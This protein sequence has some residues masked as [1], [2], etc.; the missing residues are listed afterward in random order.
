RLLGL[1][2]DQWCEKGILGNFWETGAAARQSGVHP[3]WYALDWMQ[4]SVASPQHDSE[5]PLYRQLFEQIATR[6]RSGDLARGARLP[7]TRDLA[8]ILGL[9]RPT[10]SAA[11]DLLEAEGLIAGQVGRGSF[12][13]SG[14]SQAGVEWS[15]LLHRDDRLKPVPPTSFA[16]SR[17]SR[18]LFPL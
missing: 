16:T 6:I 10:V 12:V 18:E 4:F 1:L 5:V 14:V 7:A 8:G 3:I 9:N 15:V 2:E 11:Y 13:T 17:P